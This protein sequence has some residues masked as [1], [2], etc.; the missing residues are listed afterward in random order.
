MDEPT[1]LFVMD[2][3][4]I[5]DKLKTCV[6]RAERIGPGDNLKVLFQHCP[7]ACHE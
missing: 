2:E 5:N 7:P 1:N 3:N 6:Q 4:A